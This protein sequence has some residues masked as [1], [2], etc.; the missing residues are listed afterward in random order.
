MDS[1]LDL[2]QSLESGLTDTKI[3]SQKD[4]IETLITGIKSIPLSNITSEE[5]DHLIDFLS[6]RLALADPNITNLILDGFIWLTKSTWSNGCSMV[7][8]EQAKRIVQDGIFGHLTI[9][10]LI[11]SGRLKVF[12]LLHCFLT[13]SQLNGIQSMESN[14]IQKYL[15]AIDEEKDPQILHLI[16]RMNVI[17][18]REFPSVIEFKD[19][20]FETISVYFPIDFSPP[21]GGGISGVTRDLLA[22]SLHQC[23][24]SMRNMTGHNL[25]P[26]ICEKIESQWP[27]GQLD[28]LCLFNDCLHGQLQR[29]DGDNDINHVLFSDRNPIDIRHISPYLGVIIPTLIQIANKFGKQ[30][31]NNDLYAL[32]LSCISGL[33]HAYSLQT[34]DKSQLEDFTVILL[35]S[36]G[37]SPNQ[38]QPPIISPHGVIVDYITESFKSAQ[39]NSLLLSILFNYTIPHLCVPLLSN[40]YA[41]SNDH[42]GIAEETK[43]NIDEL[44]NWQS[45]I[46]LLDKI[47]QNIT[48]ENLMNALNYDKKTLGTLDSLKMNI[49]LIINKLQ[50]CSVNSVNLL[51]HSSVSKLS[52]EKRIYFS[53]CLC[54]LFYSLTKF[55]SRSD[56]SSSVNGNSTILF[57]NSSSSYSSYVDSI[58][59]TICSTF[60]WLDKISLTNNN[61]KLVDSEVL[62]FIRDELLSF[63]PIIYNSCDLFICKLD[64]F[65]F[66][67]LKDCQLE[68]IT[69]NTSNNFTMDILKYCSCKNL[70]LLQKTIKF[71][72]EKCNNNDMLMDSENVNAVSLQYWAKIFTSLLYFIC[73]YLIEN[74]INDNTDLVNPSSIHSYLFDLCQNV[75]Y[76]VNIIHHYYSNSMIS[77]NSQNES[78]LN[79]INK[80]NFIFRTI[81][82]QCNLSEQTQLF[83]IYKHYFDQTDRN[84]LKTYPVTLGLFTILCGIIGGLRP[85]FVNSENPVQ[86]LT[87]IMDNIQNILC[88]SS[89]AP[90]VTNTIN[91]P[92]VS[93]SV[94]FCY[95]TTMLSSIAQTYA[96][97]LNK[98]NDTFALDITNHLS[99]SLNYFWSIT[100]QNNSVDLHTFICFWLLWSI[101]GLL[102]TLN[103][104][105]HG[106]NNVDNNNNDYYHRKW[107]D[108]LIQSIFLDFNTTNHD[109]GDD[110]WICTFEK[111]LSSSHSR[112]LCSI[113]CFKQADQIL[114]DLGMKSI[115]CCLNSFNHCR[116]TDS[117]I[118]NVLECIH[119]PVYNLILLLINVTRLQ[120]LDFE[121]SILFKSFRNSIVRFYLNMTVR[122]PNEYLTDQ[123]VNKI[124][125]CA[126]FAIT[127]SNVHCQ[128]AGLKFISI[129]FSDNLTKNLELC[130]IISENQ[131]DDLL[132]KLPKLI[133]FS[134]SEQEINDT[135]IFGQENEQNTNILTCSRL[136]IA[137]CL[138]SIIKLFPEQLINRHRDVNILPLLDQLVDD[139]NRYVR[140]EAVQA[141]NLWLI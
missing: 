24:F 88:T 50:E 105:L 96:S 58:F 26:L 134:N 114:L 108:S 104:S 15:I 33:V 127:S 38:R 128:L 48:E 17:I 84:R 121:K 135:I 137:R 39:T 56:S 29:S 136:I 91:N 111:S 8:P 11:K 95:S 32:C 37:L 118:R 73:E 43:L 71:I 69:L 49:Y 10:N 82:S 129:I 47:F 22:S 92:S 42:L 59:N 103:V 51:K 109:D 132:E 125:P 141:R 27:S 16:F 57:D 110:N 54:R 44:V 21:P 81:T 19:E 61:N 25:I 98:S 70:S 133:H 66:N 79:E 124:I 85:E 12:Q 106:A 126:L 18:V 46:S 60:Q 35:R 76:F 97:V 130:N 119:E 115:D 45:C 93:S 67:Y 123:S 3:T 72:L 30:R 101:R 41:N 102:A 80:L 1:L 107:C 87:W 5:I 53:V 112:I 122:L 28:A 31:D 7:N 55:T 65:L 74:S 23:L 77:D 99:S 2:I 86:L 36:F 138:C 113:D 116:I 94:V 4:S 131:A 89:A 9:Q 62:K 52:D 117:Y 6:D 63:I 13:G 140:I 78:I 68:Q 139:P 100:E 120:L 34:N 83:Q 75:K 64:Q 14:F 90:T 20:L 40:S